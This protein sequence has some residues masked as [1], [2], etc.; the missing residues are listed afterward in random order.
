[1]A[2]LPV[3]G[4]GVA[5]EP[6]PEGVAGA[7]LQVGVAPLVAASLRRLGRRGRGRVGEAPHV[8]AGGK[9]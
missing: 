2:L 9:P 5:E 8:V 4:R 7:G 1:M 3:V 6:L